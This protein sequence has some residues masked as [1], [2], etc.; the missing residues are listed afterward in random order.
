MR[1]TTPDYGHNRLIEV[2]SSDPE[3]EYISLSDA[4][5]WLRKDGD[6]EDD[7][8]SEALEDVIGQAE[9][10]MGRSLIEKTYT[11]TYATFS[12][13]VPVPFA[14]IDEIVSVHKIDKG[15]EI[16]ITDYYV[17]A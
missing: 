12:A 14:P 8:V 5:L 17:I 9:T 15:E 2:V 10:M 4:K 6:D 16:E 1:L 3:G 13:E 11:A 7:L